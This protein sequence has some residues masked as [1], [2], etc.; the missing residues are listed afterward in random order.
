MS[1][2]LARAIERAARLLPHEHAR[3]LADAVASLPDASAARLK[4]AA[5]LIPNPLFHARAESVLA[6][7]GKAKVG[8]E[9]VAL[10]LRAAASAVAADRAE[11]TLD[12]VW[13]G[14]VAHGVPLRRTSEVLVEVIGE[15]ETRLLLVSFA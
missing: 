8:G 1:D 2:E 9:A 13:T 10:A 4:G 5:A 6:A 15:A 14:P 11:E 3:T 7:W 12:L